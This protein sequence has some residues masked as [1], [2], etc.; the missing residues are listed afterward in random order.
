MVHGEVSP[1]SQ[2]AGESQCLALSQ[3]ALAARED[4]LW[5]V[6]AKASWLIKPR[7]PFC[8]TFHRGTAEI[9]SSVRGSLGKAPHH[10]YAVLDSYYLG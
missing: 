5:R 7:V 9:R 1:G 10:N 4:Q 3:H 6:T 2:A 8:W